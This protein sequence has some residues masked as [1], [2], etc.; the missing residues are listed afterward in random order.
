MRNIE[1]V[2]TLLARMRPIRLQ[3]FWLLIMALACTPVL[4]TPPGPIGEWTERTDLS[5]EFN[6]T[7]LGTNWS[8]SSPYYKGNPPGVYKSENVGVSGDRLKLSAKNLAV[9]EVVDGFTRN[10]STA[11]VT[12]VTPVLYGYFEVKAQPMKAQIGSAFWL[13]RYIETQP[14]PEQQI[15]T[16]EI[17]IF[18]IGGSAPGHDEVVHTNTWIYRG[19]PAGEKAGR[20][21]DAASEPTGHKLYGGDHVYGL[22]WNENELI[23]YFD[24]EEIRRKPN[25]DW[26]VPMYIR[27]TV[28]TFP[29]WFGLPVAGELPGEFQVDH[30]KVWQPASTSPPPTTKATPTLNLRAPPTAV[31]LKEPLS[32]TADLSNAYSPSGD[33]VFTTTAG[34]SLGG[35]TLVGTPGDATRASATLG[36]NTLCPPTGNATISASYV[37]DSYNNEAISSNT[38][39]VTVGK[40]KTSV[41][42][43]PNAAMNTQPVTLTATIS[44]YQQPKGSVQFKIYRQGT[45]TPVHQ[46]T[47]TLVQGSASWT[48]P[49]KL[50]TGKY[51][52]SADYLGD[53]NNETGTASI[54]FAV[55]DVA[56]LIPIIQMLLE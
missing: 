29:D 45:E 39:A 33:I 10:Y 5:D 36:T 11:Y 55:N 3:R 1:M 49:A 54:E 48:T 12:S 8:T 42:L 18:E 35:A 30:F 56:A 6:G 23:F 2:L 19:P 47:E 13:Y 7:S 52:I 15:A 9:A 14:P 41:Q 4:A 43:A 20:V 37:G 32:L 38:V 34:C 25:T 51:T 28:D 26:H 46:G 31:R 40:A 24:N 17:D 16:Y 44:G 27:F 21:P 53:E 22:E 50:A